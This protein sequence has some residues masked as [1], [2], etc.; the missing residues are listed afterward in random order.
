MPRTET[1]VA[2][3]QAAQIPELLEKILLEL[4]MQDLLLAQRVAK[5]WKMLIEKS[6]HLRRA[7]FI[8]PAACGSIS[9]I[10]WRLGRRSGVENHY[11]ATT[12]IRADDKEFYTERKAN[13]GLGEPLRG[14]DGT[15][16][17]V[18]YP[19]HWGRTR[20]DAGTYKVFANP[21]LSARFP[22]LSRSGIYN[23]EAFTDL[24]PAMQYQKA[25]WR[26]MLITQPPTNFLAI[27]WDSE[28]FGEDSGT[29]SI[30]HCESYPKEAGCTML[31]LFARLARIR[32]AAWI[33]GSDM[34]EEWIGVHNLQEITR[35]KA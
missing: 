22:V 3:Q 10:D 4:P 34:W 28:G 17:L 6:I 13:L 20:G 31:D 14:E 29:W 8:E 21:L 7:L 16:R 35:Q 11:R 27:E 33:Q 9:Y 18:R 12:D 32:G 15:K 2:S 1:Y 26:Q 19:A 25:S 5:S 30:S 24:P 23:G